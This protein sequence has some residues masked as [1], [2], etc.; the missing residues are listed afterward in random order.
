MKQE[1]REL[2]YARM[3]RG[4]PYEDLFKKQTSPPFRQKMV[5]QITTY[6]KVESLDATLGSKAR[7]TGIPKC[8]CRILNAA[9]R[10]ANEE[11]QKADAADGIFPCDI[12]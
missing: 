12:E 4:E 1:T 9:Y 2:I 7:M 11:C 3:I 10:R 6:R 8:V 5:N